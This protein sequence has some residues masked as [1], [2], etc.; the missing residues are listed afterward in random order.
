MQSS[1]TY[2]TVK[3]IYLLDITIIGKIVMNDSHLETVI[4]KLVFQNQHLNYMKLS[5]LALQHVIKNSL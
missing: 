4:I 5:H 2:Y 3:T 1:F